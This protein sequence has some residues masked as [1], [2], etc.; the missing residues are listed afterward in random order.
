MAR[1]G[2]RRDR[3]AV[4]FQHSGDVGTCDVLIDCCHQFKSILL[5]ELFRPLWAQTLAGNIP[6]VS[7]HRN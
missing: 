5:S 1:N 3:S 7:M 2:T 6:T 4:E